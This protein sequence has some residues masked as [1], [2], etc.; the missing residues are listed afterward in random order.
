M[1]P[2]AVRP[3]GS[4]GVV[5]REG[6]EQAAARSRTSATVQRMRASCGG[7]GLGATAQSHA[8][9]S[10]TTMR[11][12]TP[13]LL[14]MTLVAACATEALE[15]REEEAG[16]DPD[17]PNAALLWRAERQQDENGQI[18]PQAWQRALQARE[19]LGQASAATDDGGIEIGRAHV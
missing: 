18:P 14:T 17:F 11:R 6:P 19:A 12:L 5:R 4:R 2:S 15:W 1:R 9:C 7:P 16:E 10:L 8:V 3:T 13:W